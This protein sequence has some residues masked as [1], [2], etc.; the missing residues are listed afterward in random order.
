M[1]EGLLRDIR[2]AFI[3]DGNEAEDYE[4]VRRFEI[5][6]IELTGPEERL[7]GELARPPVKYFHFEGTGLFAPPIFYPITPGLGGALT[8]SNPGFF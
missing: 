5:D 4:V 6:W 2:L 7:Q 8:L 3:L 1:W